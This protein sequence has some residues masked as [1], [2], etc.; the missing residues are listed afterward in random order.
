MDDLAPYVKPP[1]KIVKPRRRAPRRLPVVAIVGTDTL[2]EQGNIGTVT[3]LIRGL[4][5]REPTLF[6]AIQA[7]GFIAVL[8]NVFDELPAW[9]WRATV[10]ERDVCRPDGTI[11]A[12]RVSTVIRYFGFRHHNFHKI[13]DPITMYGR[14]TGNLRP[15]NPNLIASLLKWGVNIRDFCDGNSIEVRPTMGSLAGQFLTD[16]RFY[17]NARRKVPTATNARMREYLP[18][19][20]YRLNVQPEAR[21]QFTALYLDQHRAHHYHAR[22]LEFPDANLLYAFGN[23]HAMGGIAFTGTWPNFYGLYCLDLSKPD[24]H[25]SYFNWLDDTKLDKQFVYSNELPVLLDMGYAV[26]GVRAA[27]GSWRKETG[28]NK[29]AAWAETQLDANNDAAWLKPIL[30]ATYGVLATKPRKPH[31]V[32]KRAS[33]GEPAILPT[34]RE[35]LCGLEIKGKRKL[36]PGTANVLHRGM[37]EAATRLESIT[38]ARHLD[39]QGFTVLSIYADAVIVQ[40]DDDNP[41]PLLLPPWEIKETLNHLQFINHQAFISGEMTKLPG[42]NRELLAYSRSGTGHAPRKRAIEALTGREIPTDKRI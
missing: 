12:T 21:E 40:L 22:H 17:P 20:Y 41:P 37:I 3:D 30:L 8:D 9:Q 10:N 2:D 26:K 27:W 4:K 29:Y 5:E 42:V 7:A 35:K 13:I 33:A 11:K 23:F 16:S 34:G 19:N 24:K 15:G 28:L 25:R 39:L 14:Y 6:V 1:E 32:F 36:E 18:G 31:S 38:Y